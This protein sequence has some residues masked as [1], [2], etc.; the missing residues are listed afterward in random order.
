M[1]SIQL[2]ERGFGNWHGFAPNHED[3]LVSMLPS[4]PGVYAIRRRT[5]I[6]RF[7]GSSDL[8]YIG[9][10]SNLRGLKGRIRQYFHPG[11]TQ[12]TNQRIR[13]LIAASPD[14]EIGYVRTDTAMAAVMLEST[15]LERYEAEHG[16]LPP[17]NH[18]H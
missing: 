11:P 15:L 9:S 12:Y 3:A 16:E 17:L 7:I 5:P 6:C 13:A 1:D 10:A 2:A 4:Q 18:R 8:A 14:Y